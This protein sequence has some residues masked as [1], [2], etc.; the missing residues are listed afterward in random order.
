MRL[1]RLIRTYSVADLL[2][3]TLYEVIT[4]ADCW[5]STIIFRAK[6]YVHGVA[7]GSG[8]KVWGKVIFYRF[9]GS[10]IEIGNNVRNVSRPFRYAHNIFPQSKLRTMS[11]SAQ[12][13]IGDNVGFN[14]ISILARS[15][16]IEIGENTLIGGNCQISDTDGHP[17]WPPERRS[18]YPGSEHDAPV[19][20]GANVFI[21]MNV[22]ILKGVNIGNNSVIG[23]GSVVTRDIPGN[24]VAIGAPARVVRY[25]ET[26]IGGDQCRR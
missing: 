15:Q 8:S 7:I 20:I 10:R 23:A 6:G 26:S 24:C 13:R 21:G 4:A 14:A 17:L 3:I 16:L 18:Y 22:I 1:L 19:R 9:P 2:R 12:I 5:L 11:P 25:L